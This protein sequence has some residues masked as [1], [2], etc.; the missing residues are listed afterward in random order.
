MIIKNKIIGALFISIT[1][2]HSLQANSC[3]DEEKTLTNYKLLNTSKHFDKGFAKDKFYKVTHRWNVHSFRLEYVYTLASTNI[4][5]RQV[6]TSQRDVSATNK[7]TVVQKKT[8]LSDANTVRMIKNKS[9]SREAQV[10]LANNYLC[11][12]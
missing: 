1:E 9:Q 6:K 7:P 11:S 4:F 5:I 3:I 2:I 12:F 10:L 8:V